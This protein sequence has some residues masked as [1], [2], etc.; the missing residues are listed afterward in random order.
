MQIVKKIT[1]IKQDYKSKTW[2][3]SP[4]IE[5]VKFIPFLMNNFVDFVEE[6]NFNAEAHYLKII[7]KNKQEGERIYTMFDLILIFNNSQ[8]KNLRLL[9]KLFL[10]KRISCIIL[11]K[12]QSKKIQLIY[13]QKV[14][15]YINEY[16]LKDTYYEKIFMQIKA[17]ENLRNFEYYQS[18]LKS[19]INADDY[20]PNQQA[21][22][23]NIQ[24]LLAA[25]LNE[26]KS[27]T[28]THP[29][30]F[31]AII[32]IIK[33]LHDIEEFYIEVDFFSQRRDTYLRIF[34]LKQYIYGDSQIKDH[35]K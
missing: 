4:K 35:K 24:E 6:F 23:Q 31:L 20:S 26:D 33:Y 19:Q 13:Q 28:M 14:D 18:K 3:L 9:W 27:D 2:R 22:K 32:D 16:N 17:E 1:K 11:S 29:N 30:N 34:N 5:M 7:L 12:I 15:N 10:R 21:F 25:Y 8:L